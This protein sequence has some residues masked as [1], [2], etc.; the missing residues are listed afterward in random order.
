MLGG[1]S[2]AGWVTTHGSGVAMDP[3][4]QPQPEG[5]RLAVPVHRDR[6]AVARERQSSSGGTSGEQSV[7]GWRVCADI[8]LIVA[9][10]MRLFDSIWAFGNHVAFAEGLEGWILDLLRVSGGSL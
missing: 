10:V 1:P 3:S 5:L 2:A 9:A 4:A 7:T 8:D 6:L